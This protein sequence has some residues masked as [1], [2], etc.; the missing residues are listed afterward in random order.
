M[1]NEEIVLESL[2]IALADLS[3]HINSKA[4]EVENWDS[5][6]Q[7]SILTTLANL[8]GGKSDLIP[9]LDEIKSIKEIVELLRSSN[10]LE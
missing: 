10:L 9:N 5:L 7:L 1:L 8:T 2:R 4:D 3:L 6:G